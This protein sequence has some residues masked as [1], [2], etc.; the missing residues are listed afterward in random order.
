VPDGEPGWLL[1]GAALRL[2]R[3]VTYLRAG[4]ASRPTGA[5]PQGTAGQPFVVVVQRVDGRRT[6]YRSSDLACGGRE[7]VARYLT[8]LAYDRAAHDA[9]GTSGYQLECSPPD[10]TQVTG[11]VAPLDAVR[12]AH[13]S[14]L[15]CT[16][17]VYAPHEPGLL[18][19]RDYSS[20]PLTAEQ[21][22]ALNRA[23]ATATFTATAPARCTPSS[24]EL[25][26]RLTTPGAH[27]P[28]GEH[29]ELV[30]GCPSVLR[31]NGYALWWQPRP[32]EQA[33]LARLVPAD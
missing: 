27:T 2:Q 12:A 5:C 28:A 20:H 25:L 1:P 31:L 16:Y 22:S 24:R 33:L 3:S 8:A 19:A 15:L 17:P 23:L 29:V 7:A 10:L 6:A 9:A 4:L 26:L 18:Q 13:T 11:S 32:E 30:G 21:V 14:G